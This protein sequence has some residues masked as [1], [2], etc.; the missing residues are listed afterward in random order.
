MSESFP[1]EA[2][3]NIYLIGYRGSGK[4]TVAPLLARLIDWEWEDTDREIELATES[5]IPE[6][7]ARSG[8]SVFREWETTILQAF[9]TLTSKVISTGGGLPMSEQNRKIMSKSGCAIWLQASA[10]VLWNRISKDDANDRPDLTDQGGL[11]E[12]VSVLEARTPIY[13][14]CSDYT[15][16]VESLSPEQIAEQIAN[17]WKPV[18]R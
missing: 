13:K 7:F 14:A 1:H 2:R 11:A 12:V 18:D 16:N 15:V 8:E 4:S 17:W 3:M 5:T 9:A 6:I 10:E